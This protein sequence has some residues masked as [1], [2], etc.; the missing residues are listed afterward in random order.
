MFARLILTGSLVLLGGS[1]YALTVV[2]SITPYGSLVQQISGDLADVLV[3]L[4]PGA[5]PH[6]FEPTPRMA[7]EF[8][9][10]DLVVLNGGVDE[11]LHELIEATGNRAPVLEALEVL[12]GELEEL[13]T[14]VETV[15]S[16]GSSD[17][18][19][20]THAHDGINPHVWLDPILT[21]AV[22]TAIGEKLAQVDP[23][24]A[25]VYRE[26]A[27]ELSRELATLDDSI[28][29]VL[30]QAQGAP[31][32]PFHDA[33]P[34]FARRYGLDL[35]LE[36]EPFPGREPSPR[37]LLEAVRAIRESGAPVIFT[38]V[39]LS[40]RPARIL[41]D[42]AGVGLRRLDPLGESGERYQDLLL[43]NAE[44]IAE[45]LSGWERTGRN[46]RARDEQ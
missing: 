44:T 30:A 37:Y 34:Y 45:A 26:R 22:V 5:S 14:L 9:S 16:D 4:P 20:S 41:A 1:A 3:A 40:D 23:Q 24:N 39:G 7:A 8:A 31:F 10:A 15:P 12:E 19:A 29:N 27:L 35:I 17:V 33:W 13:S 38:E 6:D 28:R 46:E 2:T 43:R 36:I 25:T 18:K 42:E 32:V 11:W 21:S